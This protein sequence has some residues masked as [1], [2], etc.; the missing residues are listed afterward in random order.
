MYILIFF[1]NTNFEVIILTNINCSS[2]CVY[3]KEGKCT[4]ENISSKRATPDSKCAYFLSKA[5]TKQ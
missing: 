5:V 3:Q 1:I 4:F 2:N